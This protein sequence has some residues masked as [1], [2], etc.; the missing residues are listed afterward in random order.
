MQDNEYM[1][2]KEMNEFSLQTDGDSSHCTTLLSELKSVLKRFDDM[3]V[4]QC[5]HYTV[6][7]ILNDTIVSNTA[8]DN[9][10]SVMK[11]SED[12]QYDK[13]L[14]FLLNINITLVESIGLR[15]ASELREYLDEEMMELI[16]SD[17]AVVPFG[18]FLALLN[19][20]NQSHCF[21]INTINDA[22]M[23]LTDEL[24]ATTMNHLDI[25]R[26]LNEW[27]VETADD[28]MF[29]TVREVDM[30]LSLLKY[31]PKKRLMKLMAT[32]HSK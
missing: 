13:A 16:R 14:Q 6:R 32:C 5:S 9:N 26:H 10:V 4:D 17:L 3:I 19:H 15:E 12:D 2:M 29:V 22:W 20:Q 7:D 8:K 28:L 31:V 11:P 18:R 25:M 21:D 1:S 30:L 24:S 27:K 23:I